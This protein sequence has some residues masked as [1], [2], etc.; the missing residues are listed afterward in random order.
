MEKTSNQIEI[1]ITSLLAIWTFGFI[2]FICEPGEMVTYHFEHF[3]D[4]LGRSDWN[5]YP[6][7]VQRIYLTFVLE[8][9]Q[10][11]IIKSYGNISCT[12][13]TFKQVNSN[14]MANF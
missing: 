10:P 14:W 4:E 9:Q 6:I 11:I 2:F 7:E 12:R 1:I 3:Y 13:D 5:L 8:T